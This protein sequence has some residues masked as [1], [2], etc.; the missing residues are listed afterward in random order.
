MT[1]VPERSIILANPVAER[2]F[3]RAASD[4]VGQS[5]AI[6]YESEE[7]YR[8]FREISVP[9]LEHGQPFRTRYPARRANGDVFMARISVSIFKG[10][11]GDRF[12]VSIINDVSEEYEREQN[13]L[14]REGD[15]ASSHGERP[16]C[17]LA[18]RARYV[19]DDLHQFRL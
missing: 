8:R 9:T 3:G 11:A 13:L 7:A 14:W 2:M 10:P 1:T 12:A 19:R 4:M 6:L 18:E 16:A 17:F 15:T 5:T